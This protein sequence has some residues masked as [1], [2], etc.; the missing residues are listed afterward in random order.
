[1][2]SCTLSTRVTW[3]C[4]T[5]PPRLCVQ[6]DWDCPP[7][8]SSPRTP[9]EVTRQSTRKQ[10]LPLPGMAMTL[11]PTLLCSRCLHSS[12]ATVQDD[13]RDHRGGAVGAL[14]IP[15]R[16][17][18]DQLHSKG[19]TQL[20]A[21]LKIFDLVYSCPQLRFRVNKE[22]TIWC[23]CQI[24][25]RYRKAYC[26]SLGCRSLSSQRPEDC[27]TN[28]TWAQPQALD[29]GVYRKSTKIQLSAEGTPGFGELCL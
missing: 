27:L 22:G 3:Q 25:W 19:N 1:M 23:N 8:L 9:R 18:G 2:Y 29:D 13:H 24:H 15:L 6:Q 12:R 26:E 20:P 11:P 28:I 4:A 5:L 21:R 17:V 16:W 7:H 14:L 10:S